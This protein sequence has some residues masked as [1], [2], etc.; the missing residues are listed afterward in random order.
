MV[1]LEWLTPG[2]QER[3]TFVARAGHLTT[4]T[5]IRERLQGYRDG[6]G[7]QTIQEGRFVYKEGWRRTGNKGL[8]SGEAVTIWS[9]S[10][11]VKSIAVGHLPTA[12]ALP[13]TI[14][15]GAG[16]DLQVYYDN[17][18]SGLFM[19]REGVNAW[20]DGSQ[21][22]SEGVKLVGAAAVIMKGKQ[23]LVRQRCRVGGPATSQ[24]G[25][26]AAFLLALEATAVTDPLTIFTDCMGLQLLNRWRWGG[27][28]KLHRDWR[29]RKTG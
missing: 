20:T 23:L 8:K 15:Q 19:L 16:G 3:D 6:W 24:R 7:S 28:H 13:L 26:L 22:T 25:E 10:D 9:R 12:P 2:G 27:F 5:A 29:T 18:P 14:Q 17:L 1:L 21:R 11:R 4:V